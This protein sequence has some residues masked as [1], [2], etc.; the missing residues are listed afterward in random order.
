MEEKITVLQNQLE[1]EREKEAEISKRYSDAEIEAEKVMQQQNFEQ[2]NVSRI[3]Q[4]I[5]RYASERDEVEAAIKKND[6]DI[7]QKEKEKL[8]Q[9]NL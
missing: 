2:Q 9:L 4:E 3:D 7:V 5:E 1:Q 8:I 6:E